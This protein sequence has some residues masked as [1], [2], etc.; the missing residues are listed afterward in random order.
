MKTW[1]WQ[2]WVGKFILLVLAIGALVID[3]FGV[4]IPLWAIIV[5]AL[6]WIAQWFVA[7]LPNTPWTIVVGKALVWAVAIVELVLAQFGVIDD[8]WLV[9]APMISGLAQWLISRTPEPEESAT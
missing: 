3:Q 7:W 9:I 1:S 6:T 8:L 2:T 5:P 4:D